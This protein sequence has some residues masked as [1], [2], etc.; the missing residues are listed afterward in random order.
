M[1]LI[2]L[3]VPF[4]VLSLAQAQPIAQFQADKVSGCAPLIV[5]FSDSSTGAVKWSW[6]TGVGTSSLKNPGVFY[7]N[8][9]TYTVRLIVTDANGNQDT[10]VKQDYIT[11]YEK[12][13][14]DFNVSNQQVCVSQSV[15]FMDLSSPGSGVINEWT[16][17]LGDGITS[18]QQFPKHIYQEAGIYPVS[19][20][21]KNEFGCKADI[22]KPSYIEV[23][24]P[25]VSFISDEQLSCG[26]PFSVQF[27]STGD[28][29][30]THFWDFGDGQTSSQVNPSH[31]YT[32]NGSFSVSHIITDALGCSDTLTKDNM[33]N[34]G[35]NTL[36]I[37]AAD[38]SV[39]LNDTLYFSTNATKNSAIFWDFGDGQTDT[40]LTPK[41]KYDTAGIYNVTATISD[42]SGC[43]S[44][45][46]IPIE[47]FAYPVPDFGVADTTL[48]CDIPFKVDF[49]NKSQG[50]TSYLW[51]FGDGNISSLENPSNIFT[52][53]DTFRIRLFATG[54]G[55]CQ[56]RAV[57]HN[58][59]KI[60]PI[61]AGFLGEF[62]R[63]CAP[64]DV[65][66]YDTTYS[67]YPLVGW[68]WDLGNGSTASTNNTN[69]TYT[70]TGY[71]DVSLIVT[72]AKGCQD[73]V[74]KPGYVGAG[75]LPVIDFSIAQDTLC[76]LEEVQFT[77]LSSNAD[78]YIWDFGDGDTAM[79]AN[80]VHGFGA[81]GNLDIMLIA[82]DKGCADTLIKPAFV[83][84][85]APLPI[86]GIS[87]R[88]LC[89]VPSEVTFQNLSIGAD[90]WTWT[91]FDSTSS[92]LS[93]ITETV[94]EDGT[95]SVSLE[96]TNDSTQC[97]V[98]AQDSVIA[99]NVAADFVADTTRACFPAK[100]IFEDSSINAVKWNWDLGL[101]LTSDKPRVRRT[102][103]KPGT[104]EVSLIV[105]NRIRCRDTASTTIEILGVESDFD[106]GN[107]GAGCIPFETQFQDKS[108]GTGAVT[109]WLWDFGNGDSSIQQNPSY[110]YLSP[111][112][113]PVTLT[114]TDIDG[115]S[116]TQTKE[117]LIFT[118]QPVPDFLVNPPANCPG[119]NN[120]FVSLSSGAGLFYTWDFGDG[121]TSNLANTAHSYA[122]TG[123]YDITLYVVDVNGCDSSITKP[124]FVNIQELE[125][126]FWADT[127]FAPCP[128]LTVSFD[129]DNSFPHPGVKWFWDFGDGATS[130]QV[131]P[132]HVYT[133]PG[134]Y[135]VSL[136]LKTPGG[137]T[138]TMVV[139][140]MIKVLGP[141]GDFTFDPGGGCPGT[142]INFNA[143]YKDSLSTFKWSLGDGNTL[144][145]DAVSHTYYTP[146]RYL[147]ALFVTD[148]TGCEVLSVSTDSLDIYSP[149][150]AEFTAN[151]SV[152][153][154][155]G[156]IQFIDQSVVG[157]SNIT[158]WNWDFG[159]GTTAQTQ[160]PT[161][162][163]T[164]PGI[165][166]V[167]LHLTS[168][169]GCMDT[170][171]KPD[172]IQTYPSPQPLIIASDTEICEEESISFQFDMQGHVANLAHWQWEPGTGPAIN[173][174]ASITTTYQ[175]AGSYDVILRVEDGWGCKAEVSETIQVN[176]TPQISFD[177]TARLGCAPQ[178]VQFSSSSVDSLISWSWRL[179]DGSTASLDSFSHTY[180]QNGTYDV[181]LKVVDING[182]SNAVSQTA[183][184]RLTNPIAGIEADKEQICLGEE[185]RF[186]STTVADTTLVSWLWDFGDGTSSTDEHP[187]HIYNQSG[188]FTVSL[189]VTNVLGCEDTYTLP[190][191]VAIHG[192]NLPEVVMLNAVSVEDDFSASV[193]YQM[194]SQS[195]FSH[196]IIHQQDMQGNW[197]AIDSIFQQS[198]TQTIVGGLNT[199]E[200]SYCFT[201]TVVTSC[202][203]SYPLDMA[204]MHCT[205]ELQAVG[206]EQ[207][208]LL[209]WQPYQGWDE[210]NAYDIYRVSN[211]QK[212]NIQWIARVVGTESSY[213]DTDVH[214][215]AAYTY[216]IVANS[217]DGHESYS[218]TASASP[219]H[220]SPSESLHLIRATV[221]NNSFVALEWELPPVDKAEAVVIERDGGSG[222][223]EISRQ[224]AQVGLNKYQ[225]VR[226]NVQSDENT[227]R[228]F[229]LD[230]CGD[231]TPL[232]RHGNNMVLTANKVAGR[233]DVAWTPYRGWEQGVEAYTLEIFNEATQSFDLV[234]TLPGN[235]TSWSDQD[236]KLGQPLNCYRVVAWEAGKEVFSRSNESCAALEPV[237]FGA[238]AFTPNGDGINDEF[239]VK[240]AFVQ[241]YSL[242]I[243]NRW[244]KVVFYT[245]DLSQG[246]DGRQQNGAFAQ[247]GVYVYISTGKSQ[248]GDEIRMQG[249][250]TLIR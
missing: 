89:Q 182:C 86:I 15:A 137:C 54:P 248:D 123:L 133:Q 183:Y 63:G 25:D 19:L 130:N 205:S 28:T 39:C 125:A 65:Q 33:I 72:D 107:S 93:S 131:W 208:I 174:S 113:Y 129:A 154:D 225:D 101:G 181:S 156:S 46:T 23:T 61:K 95:Y 5:S 195:D 168:G 83:H 47:V 185:I 103:A 158:Q 132:T 170:L 106:L 167:S 122:D 177:A 157:S 64:L 166:T 78:G 114:V 147:P 90:S 141:S 161:H 53:V 115:C 151:T 186:R 112:T 9:G 164:Q 6:D 169:N 228:G 43:T 242:T 30:G 202:G 221:E 60:S 71:Y 94:L 187:A 7:V 52:T 73:T 204:D 176:R 222:F 58:Y 13:T 118:T 109:Q 209:I 219:I 4:L 193:D 138:D 244:G 2:A 149:P 21:V 67:P 17:D 145:G 160:F 40:I 85:M 99:V 226:T 210:V 38:S 197:V 238:N 8:P 155:S 212:N 243:F 162:T 247:E 79:S 140:D 77:N 206:L 76:A 234:A 223:T 224:P 232:G 189:T 87:D 199:R 227:Y 175:Q 235:Q 200:I 184:I 159:D 165:Y 246:W 207:Q 213:I 31:I 51:H 229:V 11:V 230:S 81:L 14:A 96:L 26:P 231:Y 16:W 135:T 201:V 236:S 105:E 196:Y 178:E 36:S 163:Y 80:P 100:I 119:Y 35:V 18:N 250:F 152:L 108:I 173:D 180:T 82:S 240:G 98:T 91:R 126:N 45:H 127:T 143:T 75:I 44:T 245:N 172:F 70:Q 37:S 92:T 84:I 27:T 194:Y 42:I 62:I 220:I 121:S 249:S 102:Y 215:E 32:G 29:T 153:C 3:I 150:I 179:G 24:A 34:V 214:C 218:D 136:I 48:G 104:Y 74:I 56:A 68:Q 148:T 190:N 50:A 1:R 59:I 66:L 237:L 191:P 233:I 116:D 203:E 120:I 88:L 22:I 241:D 134:V 239:I 110:T 142:T 128:P 69:T 124:L 171:V 55:G 211:Y 57:K 41:I 216:R 12:P 139:Q 146:G 117:D 192:G 49:V 188:S 20:I 198:Q 97:T 144:F 217:V 10:L 111:G